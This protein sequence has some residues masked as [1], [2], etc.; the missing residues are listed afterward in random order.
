MS[1]R[2]TELFLEIDQYRNRRI[3]QEAERNR[4][5]VSKLLKEVLDERL[6][7]LQREIF[8]KD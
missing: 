8:F 1:I 4:H 6:G 7:S 2:K 5:S 3:K